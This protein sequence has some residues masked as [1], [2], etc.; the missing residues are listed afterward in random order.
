MVF[1]SFELYEIILSRY[2]DD[3]KEDVEI[4]LE[5]KVIASDEAAVKSYI[6]HLAKE[7]GGKWSG[8]I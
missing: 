6:E 7:I 5:E 3:E 1:A 4:V 2:K 8:M